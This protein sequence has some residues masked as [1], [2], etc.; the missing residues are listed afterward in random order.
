MRI[1]AFN[2]S[3]RGERSNTHI[4]VTELLAGAA[5]AGAET[6]E[7][8]L[9]DYEIRPCMGC[10]HCWMKTPGHC[11]IQDDVAE[12]L[13]KLVASDVAV[14][15]TPLY[16]D[17]V[18]GIMKNFMDRHIP[19]FDCHFDKDANGECCHPARFGKPD[20]FVALSNAGFPEQ[21]HFQVLRLLFRRFA[22]NARAGLVG[23]IYR[24][25]G[26]LMSSENPST[27]P[28]VA[29]YKELLRRAGKEIAQDGKISEETAAALE[30]PIVPYNVYIRGANKYWDKELSSLQDQGNKP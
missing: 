11:V 30:K 27:L 29:A 2:S 19:L 14:Y 18:S 10:F 9:A 20:A 25:E 23:E 26:E 22:R 6:E 5:S 4:M 8:M 3:P 17:N 12:L 28:L 24:G 7:V 15:A 13:E 16:V 21:S 1:T